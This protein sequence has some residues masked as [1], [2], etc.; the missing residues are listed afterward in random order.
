MKRVMKYTPPTTFKEL[1]DFCKLNYNIEGEIWKSVPIE[2]LEDFQISNYG[3]IFNTKSNRLRKCN[4]HSWKGKCSLSSI[5]YTLH[6]Y[7]HENRFRY[8]SFTIY[9]LMCHAFYPDISDTHIN[10]ISKDGNIFNLFLDNIK[11]VPNAYYTGDNAYKEEYIYIDDEK[12]RYTIDTNGVI[13]NRITGRI[14]S[15]KSNLQVLAHKGLRNAH[16]RV[17]FLAKTFIPNPNNLKYASLID[18]SISTPSLN[19]ICWTNRIRLV[20]KS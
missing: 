17:W 19:N 9:D 2:G 12:S 8:I 11:Y 18:P 1:Q 5:F 6:F 15:S 13:T 14:T 20:K 3:R 4:F 7:C 16:R 10:A